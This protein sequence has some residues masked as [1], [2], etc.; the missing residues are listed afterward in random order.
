MTRRSR[1][2]VKQAA[3]RELFCV[4]TQVVRLSDWTLA[5][6]VVNR[7]DQAFGVDDYW[8]VQ[9]TIVSATAVMRDRKPTGIEVYLLYGAEE[10]LYVAVLKPTRNRVTGAVELY[11]DPFRRSNARELART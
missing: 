10:D 4:R 1:R 11:L 8:R 2:C 9:P 7:G 3:D 6:Q 5:K